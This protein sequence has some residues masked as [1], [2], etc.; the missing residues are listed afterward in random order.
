MLD[1]YIDVILEVGL[2]LQPGERLHIRCQASEWQLARRVTEKAYEKGA[3][4]VSVEW[5]DDRIDALALKYGDEGL[6]CA[7]PEWK[8]I[9]TRELMDANACVLNLRS[10]FASAGGA[11]APV[12][13][14]MRRQMSRAA[15]NAAFNTR[16][17]EFDLRY[18]IAEVPNAAWAKKVF[19]SLDEET[20]LQ[21]L[22]EAVFHCGYADLNDPVSFWRRKQ[23]EAVRRCEW[24]NAQEF[25]ALHFKD[26]HTDLTVGLPPRHIWLEGGVSCTSD[27]VYFLPNIPSEENGG[28]PLRTGTDGTVRLSKPLVYQGIVIEGVTLRFEHGKVVAFDAESGKE[29]LAGIIHADENACYLGEVALVPEN[30]V[31]GETGLTFFSTLY[32]E[33]ASCHIALG[34]SFPYQVGGMA[35]KSRE[36][37]IAAGINRSAIHEDLMI[38]T[39]EM[40]VW[41]LKNGSRTLLLSDG[42]WQI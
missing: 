19:P 10:P 36:E 35:G 1:K 24:L 15:A 38:G 30:G 7:W 18:C 6:S 21:K 8:N 20:A 11:Q 27:G 34:E 16:V 23:E 2:N 5:D 40:Q 14:I 26:P 29:A 25:E 22:W 28:V 9:I 3:G 31:I 39:K 13:R 4:F 12:E 33:N 17:L 32:D 42:D 37:Q 41:G